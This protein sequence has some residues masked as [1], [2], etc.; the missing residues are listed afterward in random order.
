MTREDKMINLTFQWH[1]GTLEIGPDGL[2]DRL[3]AHFVAKGYRQI[4]GLDYGDT[5]YPS[6]GSGSESATNFRKSTKSR[7]N[8][9][10]E[11]N[12]D[13]NEEN[14]YGSKGL[15]IRDGSDNGSGT[16]VD[17][18]GRLKGKMPCPRLLGLRTSG[19]AAVVAIWVV[20]RQKSAPNSGE[21]NIGKSLCERRRHVLPHATTCRRCV[22]PT[23]RHR[24]KI[25]L[26]E[27]PESVPWVGDVPFEGHRRH[28]I[29]FQ[30][31][32]ELKIIPLGPNDFRNV[33]GV[34]WILKRRSRLDHIDG[35]GPRLDDTHFPIL[36]NE[37]SL[38]MIW[39]W[40]SMI[41]E[42]SRNYMFHFSTKEIWDD[43]HKYHGILNGL[44]IELDQYQTIKMCKT[45]AV[46]HA[47]AVERGRISKFLH[48]L[49]HEY[50]LIQVQILGRE[51]LPSLS[52]VFF[53]A[54][55][56]ET[57]R[58]VI[59]DGGDLQQRLCHDNRKGSPQGNKCR[60]KV[61]KDYC[62]YYKRFGH[63][64]ETCFKLHGRT[65]VLEHM[66]NNKGSAQ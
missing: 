23:R 59:L 50:D 1:L 28:L 65:N 47:K 26:L 6:S 45:D 2:I 30:G 14:D 16:Q 61:I 54:K 56:E 51:K 18:I 44:W 17:T 49:N 11:N 33:V 8:D 12:S 7:S 20:D 36:D 55:G 39:M 4:F 53:M 38:I 3:K 46:T 31:M 34:Y 40:H 10:S 62:S 21:H 5:F 13:S 58:V 32:F 52:E 41:L 25:G 66:G 42:I 43:L 57:Q 19:E 35:G 15:S 63:T 9:A 27:S 60:R 29:V 48:G 64:E 37:E 24:H 22:G